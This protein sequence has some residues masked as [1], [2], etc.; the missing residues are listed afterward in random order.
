M[1]SFEDTI[2]ALSPD[3]YWRMDQ[4]VLTGAGGECLDYSGNNRHGTYATVPDNITPNQPSLVPTDPSAISISVAEQVY[5]DGT[6][7]SYAFARDSRNDSWWE[8]PSVSASLCFRLNTPGQAS[9]FL[10]RRDHLTTINRQFG[11]RT[12]NDSELRLDYADTSSNWHELDTVNLLNTV[13]I[14]DGEPHIATVVVDNAGSRLE[15][16]VDCQL[17]ASSSPVD[18]LHVATNAFMAVGQARISGNGH[19]L[20]GN[21]SHF[22]FGG[23]AWTQNE[24]TGL[25]QAWGCTSKGILPPS[26]IPSPELCTNSCPPGTP[27]DGDSITCVPKP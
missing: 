15:I 18:D 20:N 23:R 7:S 1:A 26:I 10:F 16:W 8:H 9:R 22:A 25:H 6:A 19:S 3:V 12:W 27:P 24:I 13:D 5:I 11:L 2:I 14:Q 4:T 17:V 21:M